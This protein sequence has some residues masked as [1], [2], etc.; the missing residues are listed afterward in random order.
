LF[1][2]SSKPGQTGQTAP[3]TRGGKHGLM[4]ARLQSQASARGEFRDPGC[5][6]IL[7]PITKLGHQPVSGAACLE[8][9]LTV[10]FEV[11]P[12]GVKPK[13]NPTQSPHDKIVL[14]GR[15]EPNCDVSF[16]H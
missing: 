7:L 8:V 4:A 1:H 10:T 12:R 16:T 15:S 5:L 9:G 13:R 2:I 14:V 3:G 11:S 6:S